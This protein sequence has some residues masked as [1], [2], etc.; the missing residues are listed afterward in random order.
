[1]AELAIRCTMVSVVVL[2]TLD[3]G[4][5]MLLVRRHSRYMDGTCTYIAGHL[6]AG[7]SGWQ[8][9]LRE[10]AEETGLSPH[11]LYATSFCEQFYDA[12]NDCIQLVPAFVAF[13]AADAVVRLNREHTASQW[14]FLG[15]A[16]E[17]LPFGS[18]RDLLAHVR[19][20]FIER[21]PQP[22]L[23]MFGVD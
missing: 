18:Q 6:E 2:R 21:T 16:G 7:E 15:D 10:L 23:R 14:L 20:E 3:A 17:R 5:Q 22:A 4:P 19:R 13:V 1:M 8:A 11:A 9:A 12:G